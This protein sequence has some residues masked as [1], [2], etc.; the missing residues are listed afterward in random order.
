MVSRDRT[1][2][3]SISDK[4]FLHLPTAISL[5]RRFFVCVSVCACYVF[6]NAMRILIG[7]HIR[8]PATGVIS[9][10]PSDTGIGTQMWVLCNIIFNLLCKPDWLQTHRD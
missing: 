7:A 10:D 6:M 8:S 4:Y 2:V 1:Q 3:A 5:A 9:C